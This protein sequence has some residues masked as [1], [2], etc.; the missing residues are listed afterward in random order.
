MPKEKYLEKFGLRRS[1][2]NETKRG[3]L[4]YRNEIHNP[5]ILKGMDINWNKS[6]GY[7][8]G[9]IESD[10]SQQEDIQS[11]WSKEL[12]TVRR[13]KDFGEKNS[14]A[15]IL[16]QKWKYTTQWHKCYK[17]LRDVNAKTLA[18]KDQRRQK[19]SV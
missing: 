18:N 17:R 1:K 8:A 3:R 4:K 9:V 13:R 5:W 2:I 15:R 10:G 6:Y 14:E 11:K 12:Q 19:C 16:K 7:V